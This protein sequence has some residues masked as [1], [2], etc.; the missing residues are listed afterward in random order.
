MT[1]GFSRLV[2]LGSW[3]KPLVHETTYE[4]DNNFKWCWNT[5]DNS[6]TMRYRDMTS[7]NGRTSAGQYP[8]DSLVDNPKPTSPPNMFEH[9]TAFENL[10]L[11]IMQIR[12]RTSDF[13][14]VAKRSII[15]AK[16]K[17]ASFEEM[18]LGSLVFFARV[19]QQLGL[20]TQKLQPNIRLLLRPAPRRVHFARRW[21]GASKPTL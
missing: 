9:S 4:A 18:V 7:A 2:L 3:R 16:S 14:L 8:C 20:W 15:R 13:S 12:F 5:H 21:T 17:Q 6:R 19:I 1:R 11:I 10:R